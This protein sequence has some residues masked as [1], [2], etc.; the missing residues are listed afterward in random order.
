MTSKTKRKLQD[1]GIVLGL[2]I[3][4]LCIL[5]GGVVLEDLL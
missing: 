1:W 4:E 3:V 5:L 2:L